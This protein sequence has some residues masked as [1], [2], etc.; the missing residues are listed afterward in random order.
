ML[1]QMKQWLPLGNADA[2]A[3]VDTKDEMAALP[4]TAPLI[5]WQQERKE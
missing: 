4:G 1:T 2:M 3:K 5:G